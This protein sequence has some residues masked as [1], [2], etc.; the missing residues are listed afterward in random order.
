MRDYYKNKKQAEQLNSSS[1]VPKEQIKNTIL[2]DY[3]VSDERAKQP[4][5][6][7][8]TKIRELAKEQSPWLEEAKERQ[9][10]VDFEMLNKTINKV[11]ALTNYNFS[12]HEE[13]NF[14][15]FFDLLSTKPTFAKVA[16][17]NLKRLNK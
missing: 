9:K 12:G 13:D 4:Q 11:K 16:H 14:T 8:A 1:E 6:D 3:L 17:E 2:D 15:L 10:Q 5:V 7:S